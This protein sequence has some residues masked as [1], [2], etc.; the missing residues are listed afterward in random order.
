MSL[1]IKL[2]LALPGF[3]LAYLND[4]EPPRKDSSQ[5]QD[6]Q[7]FHVLVKGFKEASEITHENSIMEVSLKIVKTTS[8]RA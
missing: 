5:N 7:G 1:L 3:L 2:F 6:E 4:P 8:S